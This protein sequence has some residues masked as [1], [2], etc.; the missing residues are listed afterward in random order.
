MNNF[1]ADAAD[2]GLRLDVFAQSKSGLT[3]NA[4]QK[5]IENGDVLVNGAVLKSN[6]RLRTGDVIEINLP[7]PQEMEVLPQEMPLDIVYEDND[8]IVVDKPKGMVVHPAAGHYSGTLVNALL[9]HCEGSLSGINGVMRPGI[10]HRIDKDTSGLLV[11]AK[12]DRAHN[13]LAEQFSAHTTKREY[14]A[15]VHGGFQDDEGVVDAPIA[16]HK[17]HRKKMAISPE[18]KRAVTN[19]QVMERLG[20][21]TLVKCVLETGRTHQIRVHMASIGRPVLG[22]IV[23]GSEKQSYSTSGQVL[24]AGLLGFVHPTS[25]QYME[26]TSPLPDYFVR[27]HSIISAQSKQNSRKDFR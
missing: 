8:L 27:V 23:Y 21:Y 9:H 22:D 26:F 25:G 17:V 7:P 20:R 14:F 3:R 16:R 15:I 4:V 18:G 19:W 12:N 5:L 6:Y 24:H 2:V 10:V 11:I 1:S 13:G